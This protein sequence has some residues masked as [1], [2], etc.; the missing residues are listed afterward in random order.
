L[1]PALTAR[2]ALQEQSMKEYPEPLATADSGRSQSSARSMVS[3][4]VTCLTE[5]EVEVACGIMRGASNKEIAAELGISR[6]TVR[7]HVSRLLAKFDV[8]S[9]T[10]L[11][12]VLSSV[13]GIGAHSF[14]SAEHA[15]DSRR[16]GESHDSSGWRGRD[17]RS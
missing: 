14:G 4:R 12:I 9:R 5:R 3:A 1:H 10:G 17:N 11:A 6:H 15:R 13:T 2:A 7:D 16:L 8:H